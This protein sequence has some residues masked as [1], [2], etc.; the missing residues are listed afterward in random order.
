MQVCRRVLG[1]RQDAEDAFQATFVVLLRRADQIRTPESLPNWLHGVAV[2]VSRKLLTTRQ[3]HRTEPLADEPAAGESGASAERAELADAVDAEVAG[4]PVHY[5]APVVLCELLGRSRRDA[6][7]EL[8]VPEGT[9]SSRLAAAR[10]LL[11]ER[12]AARGLGDVALGAVWAGGSGAAAVPS[13]LAASTVRIL[14]GAGAGELASGVV[15]GAIDR[16]AN[17]VMKAMIVNRLRVPFVVSAALIVGFGTLMATLGGGNKPNPLVATTTAAPAPKQVRDNWIWLRVTGK[18]KCKFVAISPNGQ[19]RREIKATNGEVPLWVTPSSKEMWFAEKDPFLDLG[20][21]KQLVF[22]VKLHVRGIDSQT[23]KID[24]G[25][26]ADY[27]RAFLSR[28]GKTIGKFEIVQIGLDDRPD[29]D[30]NTLVDVVTKREKMLDLPSDHMMRDL[31][32]DGRWVLTTRRIPLY[33]EAIPWSGN[34]LYR[35]S[36]DGGTPRLLSASI[37]PYGVSISPDGKRVLVFGEDLAGKKEATW[38]NSVFV[39]DVETAKATCIGGEVNQ[40]FSAG[41]WSPDS[42]RIAYAWQRGDNAGD[43]STVPPTRLVVCDDDGKNASTVMTTDDY[44][45]PVAWW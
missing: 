1:H 14:V 12:F 11:A 10:K 38:Q 39:I 41:V 34:R 27:R 15:P 2:R 42:R 6:A 32:P 25:I 29:I 9:L 31:A 7:A 21:T 23:E 40:R 19:I 26:V 45:L 18:M 24:T 44:V 20:K 33:N 28:N 30:K 36:V 3:R 17:G 4:L 13:A 35:A 37:V 43:W 22:A 5:R 8:G 16:I